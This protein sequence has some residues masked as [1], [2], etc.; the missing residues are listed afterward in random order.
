MKTMKVEFYKSVTMWFEA[1]HPHHEEVLLAPGPDEKGTAAEFSV[2]FDYEKQP[3]NKWLLF[4]DVSISFIP[5]AKILERSCFRIGYKGTWADIFNKSL[6]DAL[7]KLAIERTIE[8]F[9]K[10]CRETDDSFT[11]EVPGV[12][13]LAASFSQGI[14]DMY[15]QYRSQD[16]IDNKV[17][18]ENIYLEFIAGDD[19]YTLTAVTFFVIDALLFNFDAFDRKNNQEQFEKLM[20]L[21]YYYSIKDKCADVQEKDTDLTIKQSILFLQCLD[22]ALQMMM[23]DLEPTLM[24]LLASTGIDQETRDEYIKLGTAY[25]DDIIK[26]LKES[27][28]TLVNLEEKYDW[29][30]LIR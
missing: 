7:L 8:T 11:L 23:G 22:F 20:P 25:F 9:I 27:K 21:T 26:S 10:K 14:I 18:D 30:S 15:Q 12:E 29:N 24:K 4:L 1:F 5:R 3:K 2:G 17:L 28:S 19:P 13:G 6:L 16:D